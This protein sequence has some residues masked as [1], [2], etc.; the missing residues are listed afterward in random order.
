MQR[1]TICCQ[2]VT[3]AASSASVNVLSRAG[4]SK[5]LKTCA[6]LMVIMRVPKSVVRYNRIHSATFRNV[7]P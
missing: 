7:A 2:M 3:L 4:S 5:G 1:L 6:V